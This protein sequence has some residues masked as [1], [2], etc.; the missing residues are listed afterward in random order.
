MKK[1]RIFFGK[2]IY[3]LFA[4]RLP[5]S[6]HFFG[7]YAKL[8]RRFCGKL[9]LKKCGKKVNIERGAVFSSHVS[10]GDY[11]GIGINASLT[12]S[13][14]IGKNVMMGPNCTM[15]SRNHAFDR[16]D[17]PMIKQGYKPEKEIVIEDDV[18]IGGHVIILP[19][20]HVGKGVIIGAGAVV[21][22]NIPDYAI[23]GGNPAK[24]IKYRNGVNN[25]K[26]I[27]FTSDR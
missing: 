25:E 24:I 19:G 17:I 5:I 26:E 27:Y 18:W 2:F 14:V 7:H 20:V 3:E 8:S 12:G 21:T 22:K 6:Y 4:K 13:V 16:I 23:V 11:S 9:I 1:I 15:Y 10:L